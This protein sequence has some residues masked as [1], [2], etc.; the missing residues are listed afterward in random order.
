M[1]TEGTHSPKPLPNTPTTNFADREN[2][3]NQFLSNQLDFS[4]LVQ[5]WEKEPPPPPPPPSTDGN[6]PISPTASS[7]ADPYDSGVYRRSLE[8]HPYPM[9]TS[10]PQNMVYNRPRGTSGNRSGKVIEEL[11]TKLEL[12]HREMVFTKQQLDIARQT[13]SNAEQTAQDLS[14]ANSKLRS[15]LTSLM[16]M[17]DRKD[18]QIE[19]QKNKIAK[20]DLQLRE[21]RDQSVDAKDQLTKVI[22]GQQSII[23]ER[24]RAVEQRL[25]AE[26]QYAALTASFASLHAKYASDVAAMK[27]DI[28]S[29]REL[30]A[31]KAAETI[32]ASAKTE[33]RVAEILGSRSGEVD[34][35][36]QAQRALDVN[37]QKFAAEV[38]KEIDKLRKEMEQS[39]KV[40]ESYEGVVNNT[41]V[42]VDALL[43][44]IR[45]FKNLRP[46]T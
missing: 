3:F 15:E 36:E 30:V 11:Q 24:D 45:N 9:S 21:Q 35:V 39:V 16:S 7:N 5:L 27:S 6:H 14:N 17:N 43:V 29:L 37:R 34:R 18:W 32:E 41:K 25:L 19:E 38:G 10:P 22:Q 31:Q 1:A 12:S 26:Q 33:K 44:K 4:N 2:L 40:T 23:D 13:K 28:T 20:L 8:R 46:E 42:E